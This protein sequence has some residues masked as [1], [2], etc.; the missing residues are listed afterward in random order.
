M[1]CP[2]AFSDLIRFGLQ[3][4]AHEEIGLTYESIILCCNLHCY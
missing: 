4:D 1:F 3:I 2:Y